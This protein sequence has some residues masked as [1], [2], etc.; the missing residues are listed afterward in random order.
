MLPLSNSGDDLASNLMKSLKANS[1]YD[2][3]F[4]GTGGDNMMK[5]GL[6]IINH[7]SEFKYIGFFEIIKNLTKILSILDKNYKKILLFKP[8][9][10]ITIDSPEF[11]F[12]LVKKLRKNNTKAKYVHYVAPSVWAWRPW[13]AKNV[14][15]LYDLLL[16]IFPF[17]NSY[18]E[19]YNLKTVFVGHPIFNKNMDY[20]ISNENLFL[21][22]LPGSRKGEISSLLPYFEKISEYIYTNNIK[23]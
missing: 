20:N 11:S 12:R 8:D 15:R 6:G 14:A 10:I 16:T 19:K 18:F 2:Y 17:E 5:E 23:I 21:A 9:L 22:L 4:C 13:R 3:S 7:I 1:F